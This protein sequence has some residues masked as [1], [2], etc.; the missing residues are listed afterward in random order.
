[1]KRTFHWLAAATVMLA[2]GSAAARRDEPASPG[3]RSSSSIRGLD[4]SIRLEKRKF[5]PDEPVVLEAIIGNRSSSPVVLGDSV[6]DLGSFDFSIEYV[7]GGHFQ[8][9]RM[10]LTHYGAALLR[11]YLASKNIPIRLAT[12]AEAVYRFP[13]SRTVDLTLTGT[14]AVRVDRFVPGAG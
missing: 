6:S 7:A 11:T 3:S 2:A 14:Y 12:G 13:L 1:M 8:H 9:T 10:P 4:L 5:A